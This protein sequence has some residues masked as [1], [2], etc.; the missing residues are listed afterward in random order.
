GLL[1]LINDILDLQ[2][3]EA[4]KMVLEE[5]EF[6]PEELLR[7]ILYA[8]R[9][10]AHEKGVGIDCQLAEGL[11]R[12]LRG[13]PVRLMQIL[14]N[15]VGNAVK[16]TDRGMVTLA[17]R[18]VA[19]TPGGTTL[20]FSVTD[21]GIGIAADKLKLIFMAFEQADADTTRR[22]GGTGLG[23]AITKRLLEMQG[24][25][26]E[27]ESTP[28][29]GSTFHFTLAFKKATSGAPV[30]RPEEAVLGGDLGHVRLL[31][32][33]DNPVNVMVARKYLARWNITPDHAPDGRAALAR[34]QE[35]AY[36]VVLM[37]LQ[38]PGMDG[39]E[40]TLAIR[41]LGGPYTALPIIALTADIS[42]EVKAQS[43]A[44]G[45]N[46]FLTKPYRPADLFQM[47]TRFARPAGPLPVDLKSAGPV[48]T[49]YAFPKID[50]LAAG[51]EAFSR[52]M[53]A[54]C[55]VELEE[56]SLNLRESILGRDE[57]RFRAALHKAKP[58]FNLLDLEDLETALTAVRTSIQ[59]A[60]DEAERGRLVREIEA[61]CGATE[62]RLRE[63]LLV[64]EPVR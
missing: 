59:H 39:L 28:G 26:I 64:T 58:L 3:I 18:L 44:V 47:L 2:K 7:N 45:M 32:A 61:V 38:M 62:R 42:A 48:D 15:L 56:C 57:A 12:A 55:V 50:E 52:Q 22:Y 33:E 8:H 16:F 19:E 21:T 20:H 25:Q 31:L 36:D 30:T 41:R 29:V 11:P 27:V 13:D 6:S 9:V 51:D 49:G 5:I 46:D 1:A 37:D 63:S 34:V 53:K 24:S 17:V 10:K 4:G 60:A 43:L 14:N 35:K 23:L 40:A 54:S